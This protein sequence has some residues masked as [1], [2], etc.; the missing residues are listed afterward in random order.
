M[1]SQ[2]QLPQTV[3]MYQASR[4]PLPYKIK[5]K[6]TRTTC[7]KGNY[8]PQGLPVFWWRLGKGKRALQEEVIA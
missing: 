3:Q 8:Y 5:K 7:L 2:L 1:F 4:M 6:A